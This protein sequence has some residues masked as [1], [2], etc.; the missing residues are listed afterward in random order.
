[1]LSSAYLIGQYKES[2]DQ[3]KRDRHIERIV[4]SV[5][6][7]TDIL[8]DFLSVGKIEEGKIQVRYAD[9]DIRQFMESN[10]AEL[11][12]ICKPGQSITYAHSGGGTL[13]LD[14]SLLKHIVQNLVSNAIKFSP[15]GTVVSVATR[16]DGQDFILTV[17][18]KGIGISED[19]RRQ[20]FQR[21]FRGA[22]ATNIQG[23]GLGLHI[24]AKYAELM[25][26]KV[27]CTSEPGKGTS[28]SVNFT[29]QETE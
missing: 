16:L 21:F 19:D 10:I 26:G 17:S 4:S 5:N 22:N 29:K 9:I 3:P 8:N 18:D 27:S 12:T 6:M 25:H 2:E 7:L 24:V 23:T 15:E 28:F 13:R 1:V 20:L 14:P 11:R